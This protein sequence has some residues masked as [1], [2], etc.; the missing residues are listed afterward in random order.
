MEGEGGREAY[1]QDVSHRFFLVVIFTSGEFLKWGIKIK[2]GWRDEK[3]DTY[4]V[5]IHDKVPNAGEPHVKVQPLF[6]GDSEV[7]GDEQERT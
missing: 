1:R 5:P 7:D 4:W 2:A 6:T 3:S